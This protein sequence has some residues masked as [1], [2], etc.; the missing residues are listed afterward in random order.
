MEIELLEKDRK[1]SILETQAQAIEN[2]KLQ[3]EQVYLRNTITII[4]VSILLIGSLLIAGVVRSRKYTK[5]L[6]EKNASIEEQ[7]KELEEANEAKDRMFSIISHDLR[8]PISSLQGLFGLI[9][10]IE[11]SGQ[12]RRAL[13]SVEGQLTNSAGLLENLL[14]WSKTQ[15]SNKEPKFEEIR[16][17][18]LVDE[19]FRLFQPNAVSKR[20]ELKSSV[21]DGD[22]V[23]SDR[24]IVDITLR[25]I[26]QNAIKFTEEG[27]SVTV[28]FSQNELESILSITDTGVGIK[29]EKVATL[30]D[31]STNRSSMGTQNEK[32]SG[33][34][35][36]LCKQLIER[37]GSLIEVSS[38]YGNGTAFL[39]KFRN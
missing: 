10:D 16:L 38:K 15:I 29:P 24:A 1:V 17:I 13:D 6:Q 37:A 36:I 32:G 18:E 30:F 5:D 8:S 9:D 26:V 14:T 35:L 39:L 2:K 4:L 27:G 22:L 21:Q 19:V 25:N 34:G 12:L 20:I 23:Y 3:D 33:L 28:A 7:K 11:M 31:I